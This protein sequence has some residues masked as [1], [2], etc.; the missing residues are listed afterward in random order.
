MVTFPFIEIL[1]IYFIPICNLLESVKAILEANNCLNK[2]IGLK[3]NGNGC[4]GWLGRVIKK[5]NRK[6]GSRVINQRRLSI[7]KTLH[8]N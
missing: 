3:N 8:S 6:R 2:V 1:P 7:A 4:I 5:G